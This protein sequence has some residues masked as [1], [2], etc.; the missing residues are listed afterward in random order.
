MVGILTCALTGLLVSP[1]SW[2]HHWVW[3][4]PMMVVLAHLATRTLALPATRRWRL[5][6]WL[7]IA[8]VAAVFSGVLWLEPASAVQGEVMTGLQQ[9]LGDIYVLAGLAGLGVIAAALAYARRRDRRPPATIP[10]AVSE[11]P[12][13]QPG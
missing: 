8:A 4:A 5:A 9:L 11:Q 3:I 2:S 13:A 7:G 6:C 1:I 10:V 12:L